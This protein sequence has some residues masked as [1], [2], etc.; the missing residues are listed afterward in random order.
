MSESC[1]ELTPFFVYLTHLTT[2]N[3]EILFSSCMLS[4]TLVALRSK[5]GG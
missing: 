2:E 4:V 3:D 1:R 5:R